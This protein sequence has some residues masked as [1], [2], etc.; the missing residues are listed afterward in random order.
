MKGLFGDENPI[1]EIQ[2]AKLL[3]MIKLVGELDDK[4]CEEIYNHDLFCSLKEFLNYEPES[5]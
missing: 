5:K 4:N 3:N 2:K 1:K